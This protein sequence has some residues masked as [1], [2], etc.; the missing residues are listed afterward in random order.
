MK[1]E[2]KLLGLLVLGLAGCGGNEEPDWQYD[3]ADIEAA[4]FG[5]WSGTIT[6]VDA[7]AVAFTV[8][9]RSHDDVTR[10]PQCGERNLSD[11]EATPGLGARCVATT[12]LAL[13]ATVVG[14]GTESEEADG[15]FRAMGETFGYGDLNLYYRSS[16]T[17]YLVAEYQD[18]TWA[19]C[20]VRGAENANIV[21]ACTL[22]ERVDVT[23]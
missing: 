4:V 8:T 16:T 5:T 17:R 22:D 21:A 3:Q 13:S 19:H 10:T 20:N 2:R 18:G 15:S 9:I 6:P 23:E 1:L 14:D 12:S 11:D 7:E